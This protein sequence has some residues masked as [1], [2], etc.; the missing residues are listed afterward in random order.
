M[1]EATAPPIPS[2]RERPEVRSAEDRGELPT[3]NKLR[4]WGT[5]SAYSLADQAL[6]SLAGFFV[7]LLLARWMPAHVYGAFAVAFAGY[8]FVC[9]FYNV[10][11]L[12][13]MSVMGPGR[14]ASR[15][16]AYFREQIVIHAKLTGLLSTLVLAAGG[17]AWQIAPHTSLPGAI[18]GSGLALPFLLFLWLVRRI[19]YVLQRPSSAILGSA[20]HLSLVICGL[21]IL[22]DLGKLSPFSA[23]LLTGSS[24]FLA[25]SFV[26]R[27]LGMTWSAP[28]VSWS[29]AL[30][31]NWSYGRWLAGSAVLYSLSAQTQTFLAASVLGLGAAGVLRAM[32][33]PALV[34]T[35][36]VT[37]AGL[38]VLPTLSRDFAR[39]SV[40][41]IRQKVLLVSTG[42][43][44]TA[45]CFAGVVM[46]VAGRVEH[47]LFAGKYASF[48]WLM[49]VLALMPVADAVA[50]GCVMALRASQKPQFDLIAN[51]VA[52][53]VGLLCAV[54]FVRWW[55]LAGV[56]VSLVAGCAA[57]ASVNLLSYRYFTARLGLGAEN[58]TGTDRNSVANN[59]LTRVAAHTAI[60][61]GE[62][63]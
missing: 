28:Q 12:E 13:P 17:M 38:L 51:A 21:Y 15:L 31:E 14:H 41:N 45:V 60:P 1:R 39:G 11:V 63:S 54:M 5:M 48:A 57:S 4:V 30:Q 49:P 6:I 52:A 42:L 53:V 26:L 18:V 29:I 46:L 3:T 35:Q 59:V 62:D 34:I 22:R 10:I 40:E 58:I 32:Q 20:T 55:G 7:N 23:F 36:V 61:S 43:A 33:L 16:P 8:L 19:C 27:R 37:A 56:A 47:V 25:A 2:V 50:S 24:S 9:G 44:G